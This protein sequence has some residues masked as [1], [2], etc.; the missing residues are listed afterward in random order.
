MLEPYAMTLL[1]NCVGAVDVTV[2]NHVGF[3]MPVM[4]VLSPAQDFWQS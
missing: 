3:S 1:V 4:P 2:D